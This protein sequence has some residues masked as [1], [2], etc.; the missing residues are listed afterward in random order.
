MPSPRRCSRCFISAY[1][2]RMAE[3]DWTNFALPRVL[4][5]N[6]GVL[7]LASVAMQMTRTAARRG[8]TSTGSERA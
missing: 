7:V 4:W 8:Q 3:S 1:Y 2:M 5:L 6:T